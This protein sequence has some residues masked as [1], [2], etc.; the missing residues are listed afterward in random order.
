MEGKIASAIRLELEPVALVWA[1][2][3]PEAAM[4]FVPGKWGCVLFLLA[5][6]AKGKTAVASRETFGCFG[7]GVGL[8]FGDQ[9]KNFPGGEECFCRFLSCGNAGTEPGESIGQGMAAS[10]AAAMAEGSPTGGGR[11]GRPVGP[12]E[13]AAA[14][15]QGGAVAVG[16][17]GDV[18][19][20]GGER[21]RKLPPARD[22]EE[23]AGA[24]EH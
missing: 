23:V 13:P 6:A 10:G 9:Y 16:H 18:P 15:R 24:A 17:A 4:E 1:D 20:D 14:A 12:Q 2:E 22:V 19:A 3:K 11:A 8:G 7:G 21:R 5:A